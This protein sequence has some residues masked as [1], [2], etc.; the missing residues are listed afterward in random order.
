[1]R[2]K[3]LSVS[4]IIGFL[5]I[6]TAALAAN[7]F[8]ISFPISELGNC[9]SMSE[10]KT[11]CDDSK[12]IDACIVYAEANGLVS[13]K[14]VE[15]V[16]TIAAGGP[17]GCQGETACRNY[18]DDQSH[19]E[20][21]L[22]FAEKKG[23]ISKS[24][25][26][27]ARS[28][29]QEIGPGGC[30]G[31][32]Q[33]R[34][35]CDDPA[36]LE[37]CV[38][39]GI[40]KGFI[41]KDEAERIKKLSSKGPGGCRGRE[42][43][44]AYCQN[45]EHGEECLNF[46]SENGLISK[47]EAQKFKNIINKGGPGGCRGE[48]QCRNYCDNPDNSDECIA[49]AE[50][51]GLMPKEEIEKA[52]KFSAASKQGG[53]G[54]CKGRECHEYCSNPANQEACFEFAKKQGLLPK[55]DLERFDKARELNKKLESGG[56]PGGCKNESECM[57]YCSDPSRVDECLSFAEKSGVMS[58]EEARKGL[59]QFKQ[60]RDFNKQS[61]QTDSGQFNPNFRQQEF[62]QQSNE[63]NN[64]PGVPDQFPGNFNQFP[65]A[66]GQ[67]PGGQG[68]SAGGRPTSGWQDQSRPGGPNAQFGEHQ[69]QLDQNISPNPSFINNFKKNLEGIGE[70]Q[71]NEGEKLFNGFQR[72]SRGLN[73]QMGVPDEQLNK[74]IPGAPGQFSSGQGFQGGF[75][76]GEP[77]MN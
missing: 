33:C 31:Q 71:K 59:E 49:F 77:N 64:F 54:G 73:Q 55:E 12:N 27:Q 45:S 39:F 32:N 38:D 52:K 18:C 51:E 30:K 76:P 36:H 72:S 23:F 74:Q 7:P 5:G 63:Q 15:Q 19:S 26:K 62:G 2:K 44:D 61:R 37:E 8:A 47:E 20:E 16:K 6:V 40:K 48:G 28:L 24:D 58:K 35:Y 3:L 75:K 14:Q 1:M 69:N 43:C 25:A 13:K 4:S 57:Q 41:K 68:F 22:N 65:G 67:F 53:P 17:G 50:K 9:G 29:L 42:Q 46:A 10:C 60:F 34:T 11:F 21:C 70:Q 66:P 56:G